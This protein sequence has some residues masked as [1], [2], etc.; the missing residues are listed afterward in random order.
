MS[1]NIIIVFASLAIA[2]ISGFFVWEY[3]RQE[4][5]LGH[6]YLNVTGGNAHVWLDSYDLGETP[7]KDWTLPTGYYQL[8]LQTDYYT[9]QQEIS[10]SSGTATIIDWTLAESLAQSSGIIYEQT[11]LDYQ[12]A[13]L[14]I[15]SVPSKALVN[16]DNQ[17]KAPSQTPYQTSTLAPGEHWFTLQLPSYQDLVVP[18][19]LT[20]GFELKVTGI[21]AQDQ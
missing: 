2:A 18:V 1:K 3:F 7:I 17:D 14:I 16:I 8:T 4:D 19:T 6:F 13:R 12:T 20:T 15:N 11:P 21:L 9:Y 10:L 5:N